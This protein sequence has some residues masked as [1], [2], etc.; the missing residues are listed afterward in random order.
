[1]NLEIGAAALSSQL[2]EAPLGVWGEGGHNRIKEVV[3][4]ERRKTSAVQALKRPADSSAWFY[5][6]RSQT[7]PVLLRR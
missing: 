2:P 6:G 7:S 4:R 5:S 1:M 3:Q